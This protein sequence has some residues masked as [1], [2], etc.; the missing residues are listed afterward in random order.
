MRL[1]DELKFRRAIQR[2]DKGRPGCFCGTARHDR[3][4]RFTCRLRGTVDLVVLGEVIRSD[5]AGRDS[6]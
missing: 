1:T 2:L 5:N 4:R 6:G 3:L